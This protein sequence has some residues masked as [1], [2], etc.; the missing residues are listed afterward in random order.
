MTVSLGWKPGFR[1]AFSCTEYMA[2]FSKLNRT[3]LI[4]VGTSLT[5]MFA[6]LL[7]LINSKGMAR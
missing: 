7:P 3:M 6:G 4:S 1:R 2:L 5:E